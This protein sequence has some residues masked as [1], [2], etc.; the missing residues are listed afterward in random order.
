MTFGE[1]YFNGSLVF[2]FQWIVFGAVE[3]HVV[4]SVEMVPEL[5]RS[6]K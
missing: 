4:F 5:G 6:V 1:Q 3:V 2:D